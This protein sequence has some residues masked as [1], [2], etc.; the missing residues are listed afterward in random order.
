[1]KK[2][3][4]VLLTLLVLVG[5]A[6]ARVTPSTNNEIFT[7]GNITIDDNKLFDVMKTV[8]GGQLVMAQAER[9]LSK[10]VVDDTL[11]AKAAEELAKTKESLGDRFEEILKQ[12]HIENEQ[13]YVDLYILPALRMESLIKSTIEADFETLVSDYKPM[14]ARILQTDSKEKAAEA[15]AKV[16]AGEDFGTVA[17]EFVGANATYKGD[18]KIYNIKGT[19]F[20]SVVAKFI[21]VQEAPGLSEVLVDEANGVSYIVQIIETQAD[22]FKDELLE[23]WTN[24]TTMVKTYKIKL[25]KDANFAVYDKDIVA[26]M[27][28]NFGDFLP[29]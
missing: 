9:D 12:L 29:Q 10:D 5:C 19:E 26:G 25:F 16:Q 23:Q 28:K 8:D 17:T 6:D 2:L 13:A 18:E 4:A 11:E 15:L 24:D 14:K 7:V 20:P 1:M 27:K 21:T 3:L 22:R